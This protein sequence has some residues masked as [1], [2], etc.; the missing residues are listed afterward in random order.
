MTDPGHLTDEETPDT[1]GAYPRL[2]EHQITALGAV[3]EARPDHPGDVLF[4]EGE[5]ASEFIAILTGTVAVVE[6]YGS[7]DERV[8]AIH[9]PGRF[10]G[11]IGLLTGQAAF[12]TAVVREPG[13]VLALPVDQLRQLVAQDTGLGDLILRAYL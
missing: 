1:V 4:H 8:I 11:E 3:G 13:E 6:A 5:R 10:L 9:G 12:V 7:P 2:S